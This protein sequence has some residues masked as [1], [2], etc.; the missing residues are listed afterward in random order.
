MYKNIIYFLY[1]YFNSHKNKYNKIYTVNIINYIINILNI[2]YNLHYI[3]IHTINLLYNLLYLYFAI[4]KEATDTVVINIK[5]TCN[6]LIK[7]RFRK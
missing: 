7:N 3:Y 6:F 2:K 4:Q 5:S 1:I